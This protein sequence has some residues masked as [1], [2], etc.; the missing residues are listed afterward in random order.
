MH[1]RDHA[2]WDGIQLVSTDVT[3]GKRDD[4]M[5]VDG[6]QYVTACEAMLAQMLIGMKIPFTPNVSFDVVM[7]GGAITRA[8][9]P[10][11]VFNCRAFLWRD[12]RTETL[13]HGLEAK[14]RNH[15]RTNRKIRLLA[16]QRGIVIKL[17]NNGQIRRL[18]RTGILPLRP[19][20][21]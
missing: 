14:G 15:S 10:D 6:Y 20:Y 7:R 18:F 17:L 19:F 1:H 12:S 8:F 16:E 21:P 3:G 5:I 11:I 2:C 9:V 13:I 4:S